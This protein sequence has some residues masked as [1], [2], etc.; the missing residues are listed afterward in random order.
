LSD[1]K[2]IIDPTNGQARITGGGYRET[3][4]TGM[5]IDLVEPAIK[6]GNGNFSVDKEGKI[7]AK[8]G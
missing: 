4:K 1:S 3:N 8:K 2:I 6:W 5:L 7:F